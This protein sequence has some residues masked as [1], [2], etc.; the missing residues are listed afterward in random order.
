MP[1]RPVQ[2]DLFG[3]RA[4]APALRGAAA[5]PPAPVAW[6]R[7]LR[8][9]GWA[10]AL[11]AGLSLA[12]AWAACR[13]RQPVYEASASVEAQPLAA[14]L[15]FVGDLPPA[16]APGADEVETR[17]DELGSRAVIAA[18]LRRLPPQEQ[19]ALPLRLW[20]RPRWLPRPPLAPGA[21]LRAATR[22]LAIVPAPRGRFIQL[23]FRA[24]SPALAADFLRQLIAADL[25]QAQVRDQALG[26]AR[27]GFVAAQAEA[28]RQRMQAAQAALD[29]WTAQH[30][31]ADPAAQ[32]T[33]A[34]QRWQQLAQ[35][36]TAAAIAGWEQADALAAG[37]RPAAR[38]GDALPSAPTDLEVRRAEAQAEVSRL[39]TLY[40]PQAAPLRQAQQALA[41]LDASLEALRAQDR[42]AR[43]R[44]LAAA[45]TQARD[46][47][48]AV[49]RQARSQA[50]LRQALGGFDLAQRGLAADQAV[51]SNLL[52][53]LQ[54]AV[55]EAG[56]AAL[57]LRPADP[58]A[59]A[60]LPIA[61]S[62][63]AAFAY[64][65]VLGGL[66]GLATMWV[67]EASD[68]RLRLPEAGGLEAPLVAWLPPL[69]PAPPAAL[70]APPHPVLARGLEGCVAALLLAQGEADTRVVYVTSAGRGEGKTTVAL[71]LAQALAQAA[72]AVLLLDGNPHQPALHLRAG[73]EA[74]PGL[75]E[76]LA[77]RATV[78]QALRRGEGAAGLSYIPAGAVGV[79][80][81][82][83][84]GLA[85][86]AGAEL[87]AAARLR[88]RWI[89]VDGGP[90]LAGPEAGIWASLADCCLL[91]AAERRTSRRRLQQAL[92]L[93]AASGVAG[94]GLVL[95]H[96]AAA[97]HLAL[98]TVWLAAPGPGAA[99]TVTP[100][101]QSA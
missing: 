14:P 72:P 66:L 32:L 23:R 29:R 99:S 15:R 31:L 43:Q 86:G 48:G 85:S 42:A 98:P 69:A 80:P 25:R 90:L 89:V 20:R 82:L 74:A 57:P 37:A 39:S 24:A 65:L 9:R 92:R 81:G 26:R 63:A 35:A 2:R 34:T 49:A 60:E 4:A 10:L 64:A 22:Q 54:Q 8:R 56:Q 87:L 30:G 95:N 52:D 79:G 19:Q 18:A 38:G 45:Q 40:Q 59:A 77:G 91:V 44:S 3:R 53:Q 88:H 96:A 94:C 46:L 97:R 76:L 93:V 12:A 6:G 17:A 100:M 28:A 50:A 33:L 83:A 51:Y 36:Q 1:P 73:A 27:V 101:R 84:V 68:D 71:H 41:S 70:A 5:A 61:P 21:R 67:L 55:A 78:E 75:A 58:A 47:A 7:L 16:P 13:W 11:V 62:R